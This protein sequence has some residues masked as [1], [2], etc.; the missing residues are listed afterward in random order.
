M[1]SRTAAALLLAVGLVG[2]GRKPNANTESAEG[3]PPAQ[4]PVRPVVPL[5]PTTTPQTGPPGQPDA[6]SGPDEDSAHA[7][8]RPC[9]NDSS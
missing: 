5:R 9:V 2:C 3:H 6:S 8:G 4:E 1:R 7:D